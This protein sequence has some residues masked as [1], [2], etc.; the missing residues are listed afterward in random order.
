MA[1]YHYN[2]FVIIMPWT[3]YDFRDWRNE[4]PVR[5]WC[6]SLQKPDL[7]RMN[8]KIDILSD[9][10]KDF[11]PGLAGPLHSSPHLYKIKVNGRVAARMIL[12]KGQ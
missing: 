4:N 12:C 6:E 9:K 1:S 3:V 7:A 5:A 8:Q 10:G 11:C 2:I